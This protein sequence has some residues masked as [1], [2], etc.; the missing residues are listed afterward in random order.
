MN[1]V[2]GNPLVDSTF[3]YC[4]EYFALIAE[5]F[6]ART[7]NIFVILNSLC[8]NVVQLDGRLKYHTIY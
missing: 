5:V 6:Q 1:Y 4:W 2:L 7:V 3:L 8:K